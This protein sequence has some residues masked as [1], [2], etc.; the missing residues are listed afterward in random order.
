MAFMADV[1]PDVTTVPPVALVIV[2]VV[3]VAL[4]K[5]GVYAGVAGPDPELEFML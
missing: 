2:A 5:G 1:M 3:V 4:D